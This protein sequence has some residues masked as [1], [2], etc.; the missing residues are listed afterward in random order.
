[1]GHTQKHKFY[2][3]L[4]FRIKQMRHLNKVSQEL[5]AEIIGVSKQTIQRYES[6][7]IHISP[8]ALDK[9]ARRLNTPVGFFYGEGETMPAPSNTNKTGLLIAADIMA[10]PDNNIRK[11]VYHLVRA[12]NRA[13]EDNEKSRKVA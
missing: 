1:M 6:G 11:S 9:C 13:H 12:I 2:V 7:E 4:G 5:L 10:I 3:D 8:E